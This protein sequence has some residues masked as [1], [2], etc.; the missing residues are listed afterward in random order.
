MNLTTLDTVL[1][2]PVCINL[3]LLQVYFKTVKLYE[4]ME[5]SDGNTSQT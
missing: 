1:F 5:A 4:T 3:P 2:Q